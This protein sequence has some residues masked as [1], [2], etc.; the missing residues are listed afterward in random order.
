MQLNILFVEDDSAD[1]TQIKREIEG[2]FSDKGID[3]K[4]DG[5]DDFD[6]AFEA[7]N[8]PHIRYDLVVTDTYRGL[9]ANRD[10]AALTT[11]EKF[12]A[13]RFAP[14]VVCSSGECPAD[15]SP[16]VFINWADKSKA[17]DIIRAINE[18]VELGIPQLARNLHD[19]LDKAAGNYLWE[20]L[21]G[22]WGKLKDNISQ[23]Q[24]DRI[25]RRRAALKISDL[26]PGSEKHVAIP[27]RH[28]LEYYIYPSLEHDYFNLGDIIRAK[29]NEDDIRVILTPHCYLFKQQGQQQPRA[30][31][32][33]TVKTVPA[34]EVL[35]QKIENTRQ[36]ELTAQN[37]KLLLWARSP[38]FTEKQPEGRHWYL[39]RFLDIPHLYCD[40]LQ[41]ESIPYTDLSGNYDSLATLAPPYAE[42][43][44]ACF[45]SFYG[46]VGIPEIAPDSIRDLLS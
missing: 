8:D 31:H 9:H 11:V 37:K 36:G 45:S 1:F 7:I 33:L 44:Q 39:P 38:A 4:V 28:G 20:F 15:L 40:F 32:V 29:N 12:R 17:G 6:K 14:V 43:L 18:I 35:G 23:E 5:K 22:N 25:I 24:L 16:S 46:S 42:A 3:V 26:V 21:E 2:Y 30:D 41:L 34:G 27:S 13:G 10:A 19:D